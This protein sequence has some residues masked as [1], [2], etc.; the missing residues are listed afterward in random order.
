MTDK[1]ICEKAIE[2]FVD[3]CCG[4]LNLNER[5]KIQVDPSKLHSPTMQAAY[6]SEGILYLREIPDGKP[7]LMLFISIAHELRHAWQIQTDPEYWCEPHKD[8]SECASIA[9]YCAQREEVDANAFAMF[10][11]VALWKLEPQFESLD[12]KTFSAIYERSK[13]IAAELC[14]P[15]NHE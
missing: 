3:I 12:D 5:P 11:C 6:T 13:Q 15:E 7:D 2:E 8:I 9:E 14:D 4:N 1:E 10:V